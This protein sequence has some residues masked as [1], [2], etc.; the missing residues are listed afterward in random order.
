VQKAVIVWRL[1]VVKGCTE[2]QELLAAYLEGD[3]PPGDARAL[4]EHIGACPGC[5]SLLETMRKSWEYLD[6]L[7][8]IEPNPAFRARFWEE[9]LK[10]GPSFWEMLAAFFRQGFPAWGAA[11]ILILL[12]FAWH[13]GG[14]RMIGKLPGPL[15]ATSTITMVPPSEIEAEES[16]LALSIMHPESR[17]IEVPEYVESPAAQDTDP[18][19][20][21]KSMDLM[22]HVD[23]LVETM[24]E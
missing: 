3:L 2:R 5:S 20:G 9:T 14:G 11:V 19:L 6:V 7:E 22:D 1:S 10:A 16:L 17:T 4:E 21:H 8:D 15:P 23:A 18:D 12:L 13:I 24:I